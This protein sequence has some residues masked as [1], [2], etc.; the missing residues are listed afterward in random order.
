MPASRCRNKSKKA[1][2]RV[3]SVVPKDTIRAFYERLG[4]ASP[5]DAGGA[6]T[7]GGGIFFAYDTREVWAWAKG[8][9][10]NSQG[11]SA[12]DSPDVAQFSSFFHKLMGV[13]P[14]NYRHSHHACTAEPLPFQVPP[15]KQRKRKGC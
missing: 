6:A 10:S 9:S 15:R 8:P 12:L 1:P 3:R 4:D 7:P 11:R 2:N 14:L 13:S 5:T